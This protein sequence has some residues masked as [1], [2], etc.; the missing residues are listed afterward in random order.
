[1][2]QTEVD[3]SPIEPPQSKRP[4]FDNLDDLMKKSVTLLQKADKN[5]QKYKEIATKSREI[6]RKLDVNLYQQEMVTRNI[7]KFFENNV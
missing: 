6:G 3:D 4:K 7:K 1:M 5:I 2:Q